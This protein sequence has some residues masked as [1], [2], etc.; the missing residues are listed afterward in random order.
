MSHFQNNRP[1]LSTSHRLAVLTD[2]NFNF[3]AL[4]PTLFPNIPTDV[5]V[6][7]GF[8]IEHMKTASQILAEV[9][10]LMKEYSS[11]NVVLVRLL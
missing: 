9:E 6:H 5:E 7:S 4:D 2:L 3:M 11:T 1:I 10:R 8:V